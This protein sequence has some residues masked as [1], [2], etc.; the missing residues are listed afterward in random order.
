MKTIE[1][2]KE[3]KRKK[4]RERE[5]ERER[6]RDRERDREALQQIDACFLAVDYPSA[7]GHL[8]TVREG[9]QG[10]AYSYTETD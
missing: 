3:R 8:Q 9:I 6:E 10:L 5:R 2:K 7:R 4:Q 1:G